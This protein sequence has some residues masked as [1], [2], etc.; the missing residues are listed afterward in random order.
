MGLTLKVQGKQLPSLYAAKNGDYSWFNGSGC[1]C[2]SNL[3]VPLLYYSLRDVFC[4][5]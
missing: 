2:S 1:R 4:Q 3:Q 5:K